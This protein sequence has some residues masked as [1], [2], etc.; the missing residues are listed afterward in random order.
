MLLW[1]DQIEGDIRGE[2]NDIHEAKAVIAK[3]NKELE[4]LS[5]QFSAGE[6]CSSFCKSKYYL[7]FPRPNLWARDKSGQYLSVHIR[8]TSD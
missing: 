5:D 4:K 6:V 7:V 2:K 3:M 1:L 8:G